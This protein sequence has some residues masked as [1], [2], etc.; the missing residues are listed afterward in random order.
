MKKTTVAAIKTHTYKY[1]PLNL[2][3]VKKYSYM[4]QCSTNNEA[5]DILG[6]SILVKTA[7]K[8]VAF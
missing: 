1:I 5:G 8:C 2:V 7:E 3:L 6:L 4:L